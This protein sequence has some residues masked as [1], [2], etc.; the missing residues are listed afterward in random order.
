MR[1]INLYYI[2]LHYIGQLLITG[3][4]SC[5]QSFF[6][7][8]IYGRKRNEFGPKTKKNDTTKHIY[9]RKKTKL[10]KTIKTCHFR[11]RKRKRK[12]ISV[13]LYHPT[14]PYLVSSDNGRLSTSGAGGTGPLTPW[15]YI[16]KK[17]IFQVIECGRRAWVARVNIISATVGWGVLGLRTPIWRVYIIIY[18][19]Y[20]FCPLSVFLVYFLF[21]FYCLTGE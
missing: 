20:I 4:S 12:R 3:L 11:R 8:A 6:L 19:L 13:A 17:N 15:K 10:A 5:W 21:L 14:G 7:Q 16:V 1:Y 9:G 18:W 2:T